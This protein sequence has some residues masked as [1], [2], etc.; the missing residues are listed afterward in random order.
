MFPFQLP[1]HVMINLSYGQ[2]QPG[3]PGDCRPIRGQITQGRGGGGRIMHQQ[4]VIGTA[5][6]FIPNTF[7]QYRLSSNFLKIALQNIFP[8]TCLGTSG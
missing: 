1:N 3:F 5:I 6:D 4:N 7:S 8:S 2:Q